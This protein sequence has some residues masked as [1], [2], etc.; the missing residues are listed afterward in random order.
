MSQGFGQLGEFR[1]KQGRHWRV[2]GLQAKTSPPGLRSHDAPS[3]VTS[4]T[5]RRR[6]RHDRNRHR[7]FRFPPGSR[8]EPGT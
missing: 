6:T 5:L 3:L 1:D 8:N 2:G 7:H 4:D